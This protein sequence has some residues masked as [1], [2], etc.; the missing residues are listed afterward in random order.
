MEDFCLCWVKPLTEPL[1][2]Q[3]GLV[4]G[5]MFLFLIEKQEKEAREKEEGNKQENKKV[6]QEHDEL[7]LSCVLLLWDRKPAW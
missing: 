5:L 3:D 1:A 7:L 2:T 4:I 6:R